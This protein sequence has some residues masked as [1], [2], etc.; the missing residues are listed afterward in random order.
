MDLAQSYTLSGAKGVMRGI[1][2]TRGSTEAEDG[3]LI[4]DEFEASGALWTRLLSVSLCK[5][6]ALSVS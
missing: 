1:A 3:A 4:L 5:S 6:S 2:L